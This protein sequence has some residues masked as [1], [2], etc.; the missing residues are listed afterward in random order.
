MSLH[1]QLEPFLSPFVRL[2]LAAPLA[3]GQSPDSVR[4]IVSHNPR[5]AYQ[6]L[7]NH[8][9]LWFED[10][11]LEL[12]LRKQC[13][14]RRHL[15]LAHARPFSEEDRFSCRLLRVR[16]VYSLGSCESEVRGWRRFAYIVRVAIRDTTCSRVSP[17]KAATR[18]RNSLK[19]VPKSTPMIIFRD[20]P[21]ISLA[22]SH[23]VTT[24]S[25]AGTLRGNASSG[26]ATAA[27]A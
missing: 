9:S 6:R 27:K 4:H 10:P 13:C 26:V 14:I 23:E 1:S 19:V 2:H 12:G 22:S 16:L 17:R 25:S 21:V 3:P 8:V 7:S 11:E 24:H 20:M 15:V 5:Y 18:V